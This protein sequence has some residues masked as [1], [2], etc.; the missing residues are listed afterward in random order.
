[1]HGD[2]GYTYFFLRDYM[3]PKYIKGPWEGSFSSFEMCICN[4]DYKEGKPYDD[5]RAMLDKV[6]EL[7]IKSAK[8]KLESLWALM[9]ILFLQTSQKSLKALMQNQELKKL[10]IK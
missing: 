2:G 3:H 5:L 10:Y 7:Q 9:N 1:M 8:E 6:G 4:F